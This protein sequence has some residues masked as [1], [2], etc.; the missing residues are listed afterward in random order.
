MPQNNYN[1]GT[2]LLTEADA[3]TEVD[4]IMDFASDLG[5]QLIIRG[6]ELWRTEELLHEVFDIYSL[7][8]ASVMILSNILIISAR[9]EGQ[10]TITR[11]KNIGEMA[12]NLE[13]LT[14]LKNLSKDYI[15][16]RFFRKIWRGCYGK[17]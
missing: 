14:N 15:R 8:D 16:R 3:E 13:I 5:E 4:F 6:G 12:V 9:R 17:H 7:K 10:K 1:T 11:Q 2:E